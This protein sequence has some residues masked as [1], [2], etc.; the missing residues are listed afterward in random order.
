M[1]NVLCYNTNLARLRKRLRRVEDE[2]DRRH[3]SISVRTP[4]CF[5]GRKHASV[6]APTANVVHMITLCI[7]GTV[8]GQLQSQHVIAAHIDQ[9]RRIANVIFA[10]NVDVV[11][12]VV[13]YDTL[14]LP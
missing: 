10:R 2:H 4:L 8:F 13:L 7:F 11:V 5:G 12:D 14:R 1:V 3:I 6:N 9:L